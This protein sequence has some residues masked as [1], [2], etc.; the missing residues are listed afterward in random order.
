MKTNKN[1]TR[2]M[3]RDFRRSGDRK[4]QLGIWELNKKLAILEDSKN[5]VQDRVDIENQ[6][7]SN[8]QQKIRDIRKYGEINL[9]T[10]T[11]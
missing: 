3:E 6:K 5:E 7:L 1:R 10:S 4:F 8:F 11:I 9:L 2:R